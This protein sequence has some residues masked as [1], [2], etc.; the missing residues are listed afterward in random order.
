MKKILIKAYTER[1]LGD[2]LFIKILCDR[3]PNHQFYILSRIDRA[4]ALHSINNLS[5]I[6][7]SIPL[8]KI[9]SVFRRLKIPFNYQHKIFMKLIEKTDAVLH[10]GGSLFIESPESMPEVE[11]YSKC[12][13]KSKKF[14]ILGCNFGPFYSNKFY[15]TYHDIFS[16]VDDICFR[17]ETSLDLFNSLTNVRKESDIIFSMQQPIVKLKTK[18]NIIISVID[19]DFRS[20]LQQYRSM[21]EGVIEKIILEL[22]KNNY[23]VT[24]MSFCEFEGDMRAIKRIK[25]NLS[26]EITDKINIFNYIGNIQEALD[27]IS[28]SSGIIATRFHSMILG[29]VYNKPVYPFVYSKKTSDVIADL[30][31]DV[32]YSD[33]ENLDNV[34]LD[35]ILAV[36]FN[37]KKIN[38]DNQ[39]LSAELQFEKID[40]YLL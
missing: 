36:I 8:M 24:L 37:E 13:T 20:D 17:D 39:R 25:K 27:I 18:K 5:I 38:I 1:N 29:W 19:L 32:L 30:P 2:D 28:S 7:L 4:T 22:I 6:K 12:V 21:Y 26:Q 14:Y 35:E 9:S 11:F 16:K 31:D 23:K 33:I 15:N 34:N 10:I 40:D 3:Y